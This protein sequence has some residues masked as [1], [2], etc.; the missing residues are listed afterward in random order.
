MLLFYCV[1]MQRLF[2]LSL[3]LPLFTSLPLS[4]CTY[5]KQINDQN[6]IFITL[7]LLS[8]TCLTSFFDVF[9][10]QSFYYEQKIKSNKRNWTRTDS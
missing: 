3:S 8:L 6:K 7:L 2:S 5:L 1:S 4:L 9:F 10:L